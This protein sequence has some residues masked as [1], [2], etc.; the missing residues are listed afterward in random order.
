MIISRENQFDKVLFCEQ[1]LN[2]CVVDASVF[3]PLRRGFIYTVCS[4]SEQS[5]KQI[6]LFFPEL[7][8]LLCANEKSAKAILQATIA[9]GF[10]RH[11]SA[12]SAL[13]I[14][15]ISSYFFKF[16]PCCDEN[17]HFQNCFASETKMF[18]TYGINAYKIT[19]QQ[20]SFSPPTE[21]RYNTLDFAC[22]KIVY[23][24]RFSPFG[25]PLVPIAVY[26][27]IEFFWQKGTHK[28]STAHTKILQKPNR[29]I[30]SSPS[31]FRQVCNN[32]FIKTKILY[33]SKNEKSPKK[34]L[35]IPENFFGLY[36]SCEKNCIA[37]F[38][39]H[40]HAII[41]CFIKY[42]SYKKSPQGE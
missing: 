21:Q 8:C 11:I 10:E 27:Q 41:A 14:L 24:R 42:S 6:F 18:Q 1:T 35:Q 16:P 19:G 23:Q 5:E 30:Q 33:A 25:Y 26:I 34:F 37:F 17:L 2:F 22:R 12:T 39:Q 7:V 28:S 40:K 3:L 4:F 38:M 36:Y 29:K 32:F 9:Y 31:F 13:E 15:E 20:P